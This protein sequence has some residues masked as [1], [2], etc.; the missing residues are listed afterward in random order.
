MR[1]RD[2]TG[3]RHFPG[4]GTPGGNRVVRAARRIEAL[5][6]PV[7]AIGLG[8]LAAAAGRGRWGWAAGMLAFMLG[9]WLLVALLPRFERSFGPVQTQVLELAFLRAGFGLLP[10]PWALLAEIAGTG[11]AIVATWIEPHR[12]QLTHQRLHSSRLGAEP[13]RVLQWGDLH[14]ER[15]TARERR[16]VALVT[17][18]K[19]DL[20]LS[21]GDF[22]STSYLD[23]PDAHAACRWVLS[24][25]HAPL[26][27]FVV[28]GSPAVD[29]EAFLGP[30]L[31]GLPVHWLRDERVRIEHAGRPIDIVGVS[32]THRP[33]VD[34]PRMRAVMNRAA[35]ETG[36][37][38]FTILL[39]HSPDLAP[40]AAEAG[41]DLML[42]G[43]THGGQVRLPF[44]GAIVTASLYGKAFEAGRIALGTMT[45][46]VS[47]GL[48]LEGTAGPRVR[49]LCPPEVVLWELEGVSPPR[50]PGASPRP[51]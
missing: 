32:C 7:F 24:R 31:A 45:L 16:F 47:R 41:V 44:Y 14:I 21:T 28:S 12:L 38:P 35:D 23:D 50:S 27:V 3:V 26:G 34:A 22:L 9:D 1:K 43:H 15:V 42:S 13:L 30:M 20:I 17:H 39:H 51:T 25:L 4:V 10:L 6:A 33:F 11:L 36:T 37:R 18:W 29:R 48:G 5:P 19:P 2:F 8:A 40:D 49:F 46:Y